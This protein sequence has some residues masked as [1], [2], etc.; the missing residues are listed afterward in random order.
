MSI[1]PYYCINKEKSV[2][3]Q[4]MKIQRI[5]FILGL[6]LITLT[7]QADDLLESS[8]SYRRFTTQDGLPQMQA[9]TVWQDT[10]GY[11][12]IGT[13]SGF[14]RYDGKTLTP[15]LK[16]RRE[17]IVGF[18]E[19]EEGVSALSFCRRWL[20]KGDKATALPL[21]PQKDLFLNNFN[22]GDLPNGYLL[23]EDEQEEHRKLYVNSQETKHGEITQRLL[24]DHPILDEMTP[25][26]KLYLDNSNLYVP[27]EK[28]LFVFI[29]EQGGKGQLSK[30][31]T[32]MD[33]DFFCL[34]RDGNV[35]Y[36]FGGDG[37][38]LLEARGER[39]EA[40]KI[41]DVNWSGKSFGLIVRRLRDGGMVIADEH[42]VYH[43]DGHRVE[44]I[45]GGFNLIKDVLVDWWDRL[46]VATYQ[47]VYCF[48]NRYFTNYRLTDDN[49]IVRA[50]A[51]NENGEPVM[52]PLNGKVIVNG[53]LISN[54]ERN[55][56][57]PSAVAIGDKVYMPGNGD[58]ACVNKGML[59]WLQLPNDK[60]QF[61]AKAGEKVVIGTRHSVMVYNG[62]IDTL[63][64]EV[65]HPW[66][67]A[68]DN[69]GRIWVGASSG[70]YRSK[71]Q[72]ARGKRQEARGK[73]QEVSG[74][75]TMEKVEYRQKLIISAMACSPQ[76]DI[77]FAS[78]DS[79]FTI[80]DGEVQP[81]ESL[82]PLLTGH[83]I[84]SLHLSPRG[85]LV[86]AAIDGLLVAE[87]K[88]ARG[89]NK[90]EARWFDASN[91]FTLLEPLKATMAES[92][93]GTVWLAGTEGMTSFRPE[94][95]MKY[96]QSETFIR[97]PLRWW[98]HWWGYC[99]L[100]A[101]CGLLIV[102]LTWLVM[103]HYHRRRLRDLER[104][105]KLTE[106]QVSAIRL[107]AI[108][109]F[110]SNVLAGIEYFLMNNSVAEATR[111]LK[112]YSNFTNQT[113]SGID[114]PAR[115]VSEEVEYTRI[116][117]KLEQLRY[118]DR[119]K[120]DFR[121]ADDVDPQAKLPTM[122]L[123]TYCQNAVKHGIGNKPDGGHIDIEVTLQDGCI[124][125]KVTDDGVGRAAAALRNT[126]STKQG[127]RILMEQIE[128]YNLSNERPISQKVT[129]LFDGEGQPAGTCYEMWVPVGY[130]F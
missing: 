77:V 122:L 75:W 64:E 66:C 112:L 124:V 67:A 117:L 13:L 7:T 84:R 104:E 115:S 71:R 97:P 74:E 36:A 79:L 63:S 98:E 47:G 11:I 83:E 89:T 68:Q 123:Y 58:V 8:L 88:E 108:P 43:F 121:V 80:V 72:E 103:R 30:E 42:S 70:L 2:S 23:M 129:D 20:V 10:Y 59:Q 9:E 44:R 102:G 65:L 27:T 107:K 81:V 106:L 85:Y 51:I 125:V 5:L 17:N 95:L 94:E 90:Y 114:C 3:L 4:R 87:R 128:L 57:A 53:K 26:R 40:R 34:C 113:L 46:W 56:Y 73:K 37:I 101:A 45:A 100:F 110:H 28:G 116:Y 50:I 48:F 99:L 96:D 32:K 60:Y 12:Y 22:S 105:K 15:F 93:D 82:Q 14:V 1:L 78:N 127:L 69:K 119:L 118:G 19:M 86:V 31:A 49:D 52:G 39:Q 62:I 120:Y 21:N 35:L 76:G 18:M 29:K 55:F 41:L 24:T 92:K 16:G 111:Y 25:D 130:K 91:G 38:Y 6:C 126:L 61:V 109:H 54:D 33:G